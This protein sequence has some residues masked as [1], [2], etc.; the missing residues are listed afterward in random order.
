MIGRSAERAATLT[1][2]LLAFARR[3]TLDPQPVDANKLVAG[4][5]E[6]LR[7]TLGKSIAMEVCPCGRPVANHG[8]CQPVGECAAQSGGERADA[9]PQGG[10]LTV[11]TANTYLDDAYAAQ[12]EDVTP[13]QYVMIAVSDTGTGMDRETLDRVFEPFFTTKDVGHGTGLGLSQVYGFIKQSQGHVKLYSEPGQGTVA[14]LYLPRLLGEVLRS[15]FK[16]RS[17]PSRS[18]EANSFLWWRTRQLSASTRWR[19]YGSWAIASW[20]PET[21]APHC[22]CSNGSLQFGCCSLMSAYRAE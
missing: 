10:R 16:R 5:S 1:H 3:Q 11:E 22:A 2:R 19:R 17:Q 8:R 12:H 21:A 6:L 9:M 7:R 4:K 13:G 20:L 15:R 18:V 14:K